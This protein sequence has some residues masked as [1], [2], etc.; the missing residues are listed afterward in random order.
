MFVNDQWYHKIPCKKCNYG[1][2]QC[3]M[4]LGRGYRVASHG[5]HYSCAEWVACPECYNTPGFKLKLYV[6]EQ[7]DVALDTVALDT[8]ALPKETSRDYSSYSSY[9]SNSNNTSYTNNTSY[10]FAHADERTPLHKSTKNVPPKLP[11][12]EWARVYRE[13]MRQINSAKSK[14]IC[15]SCTIL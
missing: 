7:V 2:V 5:Y 13:H 3:Q 4:C 11:A 1:R 8:V 14:R 10:K 15:G 12:D 9:S 6:P